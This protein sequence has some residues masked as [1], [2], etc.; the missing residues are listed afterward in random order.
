MQ[1]LRQLGA[2]LGG[3]PV[4]LVGTLHF[5]ALIETK[6]TVGRSSKELLWG[7][8]LLLEWFLLPLWKRSSKKT[9]RKC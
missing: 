7:E 2:G 9:K 1:K 5:L 8:S 4:S 3:D 6:V